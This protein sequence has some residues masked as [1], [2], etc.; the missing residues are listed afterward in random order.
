MLRVPK[1]FDLPCQDLVTIY[2]SHIRPVTEYAVPVWNAAL[3]YRQRYFIERIQKRAL[4]IT[5]GTNH[6]ELTPEQI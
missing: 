2:T 5:F 4:K 1:D 6:S 3:T